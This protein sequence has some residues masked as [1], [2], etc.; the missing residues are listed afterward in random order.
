MLTDEEV[1]EIQQKEWPKG[2]YDDME[3]GV[4]KIM[5]TAIASQYR[6]YSI[7]EYRNY[8]MLRDTD[9]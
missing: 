9:D 6:K 7:E 8:L 2:K 5:L 4:A 3:E 1:L